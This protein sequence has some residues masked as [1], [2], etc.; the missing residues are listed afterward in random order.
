MLL[1]TLVCSEGQSSTGKAGSMGT[2][3]VLSLGPSAPRPSGGSPD[4]KA[5]QGCCGGSKICWGSI[6]SSFLSTTVFSVK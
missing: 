2:V 4:R 6:G 5:N 3:D 1:E